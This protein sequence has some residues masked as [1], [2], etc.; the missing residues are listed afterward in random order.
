VSACYPRFVN[1]IYPH[2]LPKVTGREGTDRGPGKATENTWNSGGG[3]VIAPLPGKGRHPTC[4]TIYPL[5]NYS[6]KPASSTHSLRNTN[7]FSGRKDSTII[8]G[9]CP[10]KI[11]TS[12]R[13]AIPQE[14]S[15]WKHGINKLS[16]TRRPTS[17]L[18]H[19]PTGSANSRD[20][21]KK[22]STQT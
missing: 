20:P 7:Y 21:K 14:D 18:T 10:R 12:P 6:P 16:R 4:K 13:Q 1:K 11:N 19:V 17:T 8:L 9:K 15:P 3:V 22:M 5:E 2:H